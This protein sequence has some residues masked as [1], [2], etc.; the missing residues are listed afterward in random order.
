MAFGLLENRASIELEFQ[1][2]KLNLQIIVLSKKLWNLSSVSHKCFNMLQKV[3]SG[4]YT[5]GK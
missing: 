1:R 4:V 3:I 2:F 5:V